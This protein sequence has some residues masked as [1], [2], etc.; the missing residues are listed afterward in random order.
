MRAIASW[1]SCSSSVVARA[2]DVQIGVSGYV[3]DLARVVL[4]ADVCIPQLPAARFQPY[5]HRSGP[6]VAGNVQ[7]EV[8]HHHRMKARRR[9]P[10]P[11][12]TRHFVVEGVDAC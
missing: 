10:E 3:D 9:N 2:T 8:C 7:V 6:T 1:S 5:T 4:S 11:V 12:T